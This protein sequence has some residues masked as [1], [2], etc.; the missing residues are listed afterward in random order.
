MK[1]FIG[2][3]V[4]ALIIGVAIVVGFIVVK[5]VVQYGASSGPDHLNL[6]SFYGGLVQ[7]GGVLTITATNTN[8]GYNLSAKDICDNSYITI[9]LGRGAST[10]LPTGAALRAACLA[11]IGTFKQIYVRNNNALAASSTWIVATTGVPVFSAS[12]TALQLGGGNKGSQAW[13]TLVAT[14]TNGVE[15]FFN[16]GY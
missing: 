14:S 15:G 3:V 4:G 5:P 11:K 16:P 1:N 7:G 10:T 9:A 12:T 8:S 2:F 13:L 6:E